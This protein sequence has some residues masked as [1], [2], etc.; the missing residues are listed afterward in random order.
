MRPA[1]EMKV[2][3]PL[4][5]SGGPVLDFMSMKQYPDVSLDVSMLSSLGEASRARL[6]VASHRDVGC[7]KKAS[8]AP[9]GNTT[10]E[11]LWGLKIYH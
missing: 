7:R 6:Y 5:D 2:G 10:K 4:G 3:D 11:I 9:G 8:F 1:D